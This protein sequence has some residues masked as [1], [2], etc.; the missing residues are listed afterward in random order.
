M[1][2]ILGRE[3]QLTWDG[4]TVPACRDT[5]I[6]VNADTIPVK[7]FGSRV[8]GVYQTGYSI[9]MTVETIDDTAAAVAVSK[10]NSGAEIAVVAT[11]WSFTGVVTSLSDGQPLDG[12]RVFRVVI[13]STIPGLRG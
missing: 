1:S 5:T 13:E 9:A 6:D 10:L 7:Q 12:L 2:L 8:S 4:V 11:G 3:C